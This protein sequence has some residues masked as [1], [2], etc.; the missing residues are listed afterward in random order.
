MVHAAEKPR[1]RRFWLVEANYAEVESK[2]A[3]LKNRKVRQLHAPS[4][5]AVPRT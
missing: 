1:D 4:E 3:P 2:A 5:M